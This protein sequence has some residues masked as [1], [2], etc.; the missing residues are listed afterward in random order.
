MN[1]TPAWVPFLGAAGF[2]ARHWSEIGDSRATDRTILAF[3]R[4]H[5]HMV[6]THDL[7]FGTLLAATGAEGP[8]V[9]QVRTQNPIPTEIG[10]AVLDALRTHAALLKRGALLTI[11]RERA[12]VR[13]LPLRG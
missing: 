3:A 1:L 6:F 4:E 8:S 7:D 9:I 10:A 5:G 11:D 12:R 2:A 13:I